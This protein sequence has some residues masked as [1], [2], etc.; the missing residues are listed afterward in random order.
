VV[1]V[2]AMTIVACR[3]KSRGSKGCVGQGEQDVPHSRLGAVLITCQDPPQQ[4]IPIVSA[5]HLDHR[6]RELVDGQKG[7][8][9]LCTN[10]T[11]ASGPSTTLKAVHNECFPCDPEVQ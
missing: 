8:E 5:L 9:P 4:P 1:V 3:V 11:H 6:T 10:T 7:D 2:V